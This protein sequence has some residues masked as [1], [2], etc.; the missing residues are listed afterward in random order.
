MTQRIEELEKVVEKLTN[1][2]R[3]WKTKLEDLVTENRHLQ[4]VKYP[5]DEMKSRSSL[6]L[7]DIKGRPSVVLA[8]QN[9]RT[10]TGWLSLWNVLPHVGPLVNVNGNRF[11]IYIYTIY[12]IFTIYPGGETTN[13]QPPHP[14]ILLRC[15]QVCITIIYCRW[16][17]VIFCCCQI[18]LQHK[19]KAMERTKR[20]LVDRNIDIA[21]IQEPYALGAAAPEMYGVPAGYTA[22]H[23]LTEHHTSGAAVIAKNSLRPKICSY[24]RND[25]AGV[26]I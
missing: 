5:S 2:N 15:L 7:A 11:I 16:S 8:D 1:E 18:N 19:K 22:F 17:L 25:I 6:L 26:R 10:D 4:L 14:E 9:A 12:F 24:G 13:F 3:Q 21:L 23:N 20:L